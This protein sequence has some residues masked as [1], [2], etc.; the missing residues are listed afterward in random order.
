MSNTQLL[1]PIG[2]FILSF[3]IAI[4]GF[5][6]RSNWQEIKDTN[7]E[8]L[9]KIDLLTISFTEMKVDHTNFRRD[10]DFLEGEIEKIKKMMEN[11]GDR[12]HKLEFMRDNN[13]S[14]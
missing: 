12:L 1:I 10:L 13:K 11:I 6:L 2:L 5:F 7:K 9:K 3:F 4:I 8:I 14:S